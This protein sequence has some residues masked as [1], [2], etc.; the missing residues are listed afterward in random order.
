MKTI[1]NSLNIFDDINFGIGIDSKSA[2]TQK[3]KKDFYFNYM[4]KKPG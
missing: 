3:V 4:R 2:I 1:K